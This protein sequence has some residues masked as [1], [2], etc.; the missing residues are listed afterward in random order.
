MTTLYKPYVSLDIETTGITDG[1]Q[2][3]QIG[4]IVD[5]L[6]SP[7]DSLKQVSFFVDNS[8][9]LYT[10]YLDAEA[11]SMNSWI[12]EYLGGK[13]RSPYPIYDYPNAIIELHNVLADVSNKTGRSIVFAGK[14]VATF[15]LRLLKAN[16]FLDEVMLKGRGIEISHRT[17]DTGSLYLPDFGYVPTSNELN[18]LIGRDPVSHDALSDALD[19]VCAIRS[20]L[21]V[22]V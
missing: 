12:F 18:K 8:N 9:K 7:I 17:I 16:G 19:T 2:V 1:D 20:K 10:G 21:K 22:G 3:L 15:D 11:I 4:L 6:V 5:D 14:N 13:K